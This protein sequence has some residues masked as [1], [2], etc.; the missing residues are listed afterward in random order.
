MSADADEERFMSKDRELRFLFAQEFYRQDCMLA[1]Q[2]QRSPRTAGWQQEGLTP[3]SQGGQG[4]SAPSFR[5]EISAEAWT[6]TRTA[7]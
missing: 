4:G 1:I 6:A 5:K 7:R 2:R 3:P